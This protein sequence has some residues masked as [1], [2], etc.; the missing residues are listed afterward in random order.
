MA[1]F[2]GGENADWPKAEK[3]LSSLGQKQILPYLQKYGF[4]SKFYKKNTLDCFQLMFI[5]LATTFCN[6]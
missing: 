2:K 4:K 1:V 6:I 5:R 3:M